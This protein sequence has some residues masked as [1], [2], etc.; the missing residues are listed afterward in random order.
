M[1]ST[2][3]QTPGA[4]Y[5][6]EVT[7]LNYRLFVHFPNFMP[8]IGDVDATLIDREIQQAVADILAKHVFNQPKDKRVDLAET[9]IQQAIRKAKE[10]A[11]PAGT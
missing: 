3:P 7:G 6:S 2:H 5:I 11:S 1:F 9:A 8:Q 10:T 4:R